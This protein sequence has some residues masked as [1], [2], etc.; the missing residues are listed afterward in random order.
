MIAEHNAQVGE[1][2]A[3][4]VDIAHRPAE[5]TRQ[6]FIRITMQLIDELGES[7]VRVEDIVEKSG[8]S[9]SSLYHYF[10]NIR[11]LIEESQMSRLSELPTGAVNYFLEA[12]K[13]ATTTEE[14][15][16]HIID[17]LDMIFDLKHATSRMG[18]LQAVGNANMNPVF[19]AEVA[20][21]YRVAVDESVKALVLARDRGLISPDVDLEAYSL[22]I[23]TMSSAR[24]I[25][26][27][28]N[29]PVAT[30]KWMDVTRTSVLYYL[31]LIP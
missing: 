5:S 13:K 7:G 20:K 1:S 16:Q 17:S 8:H 11:G 29:D 24:T 23:A 18:R 14:L 19:T 25:M 3:A 6:S 31:G 15:C 4:T 28:D 12:V 27:I 10:G 22:W 26:D 21:R 30:E 2:A 9:V